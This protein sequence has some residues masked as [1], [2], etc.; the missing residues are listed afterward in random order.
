MESNAS[1]YSGPRFAPARMPTRRTGSPRSERRSSMTSRL[2]RV[3][4]DRCLAAC[5]SRQ[6]TGLRH[7][8]RPPPTSRDALRRP[9]SCHRKLRRS[10]LP[11]P[12]P[13]PPARPEVAVQCHRPGRRRS[14]RQGNRQ[15]PRSGASVPQPLQAMRRTRPVWPRRSE[16]NAGIGALLRCHRAFPRR[17]RPS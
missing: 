7:P 12:R 6:E 4:R 3:S 17:K 14:R 8:R 9:R 15:R 11:R 16:D 1:R 10:G 2:A 5:H 13:A